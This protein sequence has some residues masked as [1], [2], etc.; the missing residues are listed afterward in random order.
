MDQTTTC[1]CGR[2]VFVVGCLGYNIYDKNMFKG[3]LFILVLW[4]L[5]RS[6]G[7]LVSSEVPQMLFDNP[8]FDV[9]ILPSVSD[10]ICLMF[11]WKPHVTPLHSNHSFQ[12]IHHFMFPAKQRFIYQA[13][14]YLPFHVWDTVSGGV[15]YWGR[16]RNVDAAISPDSSPNCC[17]HLHL[18]I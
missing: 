7:G 2:I 14:A 8:A 4:C 3:R 5:Y 6:Y 10:L 12:G 13:C 15:K 1:L 11:I 18:C 9:G 16:T 17:L